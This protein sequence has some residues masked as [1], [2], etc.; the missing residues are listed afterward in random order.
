VQSSVGD[1]TKENGVLVA[2]DAQKQMAA[3]AMGNVP[4]KF[5]R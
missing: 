5:P 1:V 4:V 2:V 3:F